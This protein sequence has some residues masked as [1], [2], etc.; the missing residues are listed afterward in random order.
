MIR[1]PFYLLIVLA[2]FLLSCNGKKQEANAQTAKVE[3]PNIL[4]IAVDDLRPELPVYGNE[5]IKAPNLDRLA[6]EGI[7]F[8]KHYVTV[9]TCGASRHS[10]LTGRLPDTKGDIRN[11]ASAN[12]LSGKPEGELPETFVH[13]LRR[14]GY[15]T[16]GIGKITHH[17]DGY[18]YG[19]TDPVSEV[20][21]LPHSW[22][23]MLLN[24]DKWGTG[25]NAFFGYADGSNRNTLKGQVKPYEA[26]EV[27]DD[28]YPD[29][30][31]AKTAIEK[32]NDLVKK[33]Q[34]FFMGVGF[35]KPH[36][37]FN[38]PRKYWDLYDRESIPVSPNPFLPE[39]VHKSS[40]QT[41]G[42][43]HNYKQGD[44]YATLD[45]PVSESYARKLRHG[46]AACVSYVDAQIGKI[47]DELEKLQLAD[48][49]VIIVWG[50]H[51]WHLGDHRI[52]GKHTLLER[53][54]HSTLMMKVPGNGKS[55]SIEKIV[56]T[57]DLYPTIME[58]ADLE[59]PYETKGR[60][61]IPLIADYEGSN[62]EEAAYSYFR[63]GIS[64]RV[65]QY[66]L[67]KYFREQQPVIELFDHEEDPN[68]TENVADKHPDIVKSL[69][70]IWEEGNTGLFEEASE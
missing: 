11:S 38:A 43:F 15:Y 4:L 7:V 26:G 48:N 30:L 47:L 36:L 49:T 39:N 33:D 70:P 44:E 10:L 6:S 18:V 17:P 21:E 57:V 52:W 28:G 24:T 67:N 62:W 66:R 20:L 32:L 1:I 68:E 56:S 40:L 3:R 41:M 27:D 61:L 45:D 8:Q 25:H 35:F 9:P 37:P 34:P 53:A 59:M 50:D 65:P 12:E 19:Y 63:T 23:E 64:V 55:L 13:H 31:M 60:S 5:Y 29:G 42:E 51:G 54:V 22:D 46:Y 69:L 16:V 58:L 2:C 14:N